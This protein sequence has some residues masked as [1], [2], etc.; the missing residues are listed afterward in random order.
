MKIGSKMSE[1]KNENWVKFW[2]F[3]GKKVKREYKNILGQNIFFESNFLMP[4]LGHSII[5]YCACVKK[6]LTVL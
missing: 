1:Y 4:V 6:V 2:V 5:H 3:Y